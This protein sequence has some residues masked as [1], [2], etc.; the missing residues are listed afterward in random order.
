MQRLLVANRGEIARRIFRSAKA[1]G[2]TTIAVFSDADH[3]APFVADADLAVRIGPGPVGESYL[4]IEAILDAAKRSRADAVHPGYGF[5]A[6]RAEFSRRCLE[7]GL[8]FVGPSPAAI[9]A[10]GDKVVA[11]RTMRAAGVVV[12]PGFE[13]EHADDATL[14]SEGNRLGVPL[15]VKA[16]AGG[17]G[18]G[19]R[20]VDDLAE[21]PA[22]LVSA[23]S[24]AQ[25]AF[26][27][28]AL[29]LERRLKGARHVEIQIIAD[30]HGH[31]Q[32]LGERECSVQRRHQK[33]IEE[34]P[35]PAVDAELRERMGAAAV[36][37]ARAI[38]YVG[39]GTVEFLLDDEGAFYFLEMNTRLQV[40]HPVTEA[41]TGVDLVQLQL[42]VADGAKL[43]PIEV[44]ID[45]HAIEA[46]IYCEDPYAGFIPQLGTIALWTPAT[47]AHV[48]VDDGVQTGQ[49]ITAFYDPMVAKVIAWGATREAARRRLADAVA[50]SV[51]LGPTTNRA[52][53]LQLL[54]DPAFVDGEFKTDTLDARE[55]PGCKPEP[56]PAIWALAAISVGLVDSAS[57]WHSTG[58]A[59]WPVQLSCGD[60]SRNIELTADGRGTTT[61]TVGE[62]KVNIRIIAHEQA[63]LYAEIDGVRRRYPWA[64]IGDAAVAIDDAGHAFVFSERSPMVGHKQGPTGDDVRSPM[65]GRVVRVS[66]VVGETVAKGQALVTVEAM[67]LEHRVTAPRAGTIATCSVRAE[68]QVTAGQVLATLQPQTTAGTT[69]K[70]EGES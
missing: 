11:K 15:L 70:S 51:L 40:E 59:H 9:E 35:S 57:P 63:S 18:R 6:E 14:V 66:V 23:R 34:A 12:V 37:A 5:L 69:K 13:G 28:G 64:R 32:H 8:T 62:T 49:E 58:R 67:K 7:A 61:V 33:V 47:G 26:G 60:T 10:M 48:R 24:E 52:L 44:R 45:G 55:S 42:D 43:A 16:V 21:L 68:D 50:S 41:V 39:A 22:A 56:E 17:G 31:V 25:A 29:F 46:R 20:T 3:D 54:A 36:A 65:G 1:A 53:L 30:K 38:D 4:S 2:I 27:N 19:M